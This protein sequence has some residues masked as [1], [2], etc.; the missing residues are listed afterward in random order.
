MDNIRLNT[1]LL[2]SL[3]SVLFMPASDII[4]AS[5][6]R[7]STWYNMMAKPEGITIQQLLAIANALHIPVRRFFAEGRE[8]VIGR[9]EDYIEEPYQECRYDEDALRTFVTSRPAATWKGAADAIGMSYQ[10]LKDSLTAVTRTPVVRFV[11]VCRFFGIDPFD[12]LIDPNPTASERRKKPLR[13]SEAD[14]FRSEI[15]TMKGRIDELSK[16]VENLT[17]KYEALLKA[18]EQLAKRVH[19]NIGTISGSNISTIGIAAEPLTKP[20]DD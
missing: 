9:K 12:I 14:E 7:N 6:I 4:S 16:T 20:D 10:R 8:T 18:H 19:V 11:D 15:S 5:G 3:S 2:T 1:R 17:A 13:K